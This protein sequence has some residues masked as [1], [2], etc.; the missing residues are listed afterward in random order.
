[1]SRRTLVALVGLA[2]VVAVALYVWRTGAAPQ[3][4]AD[5]AA[6]LDR[7]PLVDPK[8]AP[9]RARGLDLAPC[10][11]R[12]RVV[13]GGDRLGVGGAIVL[14]QPSGSVVGRGQRHVVR[15]DDS[16]AW[17]AADLAPGVY[18]LSA[19]AAGMEPRLRQRIVL[20]PGRD[21]SDLDLE[22][23]PG[24]MA[25]QGQIRDA[26]GG[27]VAGADVVAVTIDNAT[28][29][30]PRVYAT[31][32]D[33]QGR[34][35]LSLIAGKYGIEASRSDYAATA[36]VVHVGD[37]PREESFALVPGGVIE[38]VVR[39]RDDGRPVPR[40]RVGGGLSSAPVFMGASRVSAHADDEG[41][42]RLEGLRAGMVELRAQ[43]ESQ[44]SLTPTFVPMGVG[45]EVSGVEV[46]VSPT[47]RIS[48]Y[49]VESGNETRGI[50][51]VHVSVQSFSRDVFASARVSD[52]SDAEGYFEVRGVRPG[53]YL[54]VPMAEGWLP[55]LHFTNVGD[56]DVTDLLLTLQAGA[57]I[58][59]RVDPPSVVRIRALAQ[60]PEEEDAGIGV[61]FGVMRAMWSTFGTVRSDPD[62]RF[63]LGPVTPGRYRLEAGAV[64]RRAGHVDVEVG[65][66]GLAEV[67]LPLLDDPRVV[68]RVVDE[69][70]DP[71]AEVGVVLARVR[72]EGDPLRMTMST[73]E[74]HED[75][76]DAEGRFELR[77]VT[78]GQYQATVR[79]DLGLRIPVS[80][81]GP[82]ASRYP[83]VMVVV[84]ERR[85]PEPLELRTIVVDEGLR[86]RV[87]SPD[88][89]PL[90]GAWVVAR[91]QLDRRELGWLYDGVQGMAS[92]DS[93]GGPGEAGA[94]SETK[95]ETGDD[96]AAAEDE[97]EGN[98]FEIPGVDGQI[99]AALTSPP[100][101]TDEEGRFEIPGL[102]RRRYTVVAEAARGSL[103]TEVA[104]VNATAPVSLTL[105]P[106]ASIE[107]AL[108]DAPGAGLL[109]LE[110][111]GPDQRTRSMRLEDGPARIERLLP[112]DY[113]LDAVTELGAGRAS[114]SVEP[115]ESA[116]VPLKI[117]AYATI[118]G[119]LVGLADGKPLPQVLHFVE[120]KS[121]VDMQSAMDMIA[122][123]LGEGSSSTDS[124]G[125][126]T[127]G[128]LRPG[129]VV[130]RFT[131]PGRFGGAGAARAW[132]EPGQ[133]LDVGDVLYFRE[134]S[135][136]G[137]LG[138]ELEVRIG[139]DADANP[140]TADAPPWRL[141]VTAAE[142]GLPAARAGIEPGDEVVSV[143]GRAL[144]NGAQGQLSA[145]AA[146]SQLRHVALGEAIEFETAR[147]GVRRSHS[148]EAVAEP[149]E[150]TGASP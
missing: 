133:Q 150:E 89:T 18:T 114:F 81:E 76:T 63:T 80:A 2:V 75:R 7:T 36:R 64:G 94:E 128:R 122:G 56:E 34:Y 78:P 112:G 37:A 126:F 77:G 132:V 131:A 26:A 142:L 5:A 12:G 136:Q 57:M 105:Q 143:G 74:P 50:P 110:L 140:A 29:P 119:R 72:R 149:S 16:G 21:H 141:W 20:E 102:P 97:E 68:G 137:T 17:Q 43:G 103:R 147:G 145:N 93:A 53:R 73:A 120:S 144:G 107:L 42:F 24:G 139:K 101:L 32:A 86:G 55:S 70:G 130:I 91:P 4:T 134:P 87:L 115:G 65:L 54:T 61:I 98:S 10:S 38:G 40:A 111:D 84:E 118:E 60:M 47:F 6:E 19:T 48:G 146:R 58:E 9:R 129:W 83:K 90:A 100:V 148:L 1:M 106:L 116:S 15:A 62:G 11:A 51:G 33:K 85:D 39:N 59:G 35:S 95:V 99:V 41:R 52:P 69:D 45:E 49:V 44:G 3:P 46:L 88:G 13:R 79:D 113:E 124:E 71:V 138:L 117:E 108:E 14:L 104:D 109:E 92:L 67:A 82:V 127:L 125:R 66:D 31:Q 96:A 30:D 23:T 28:S 27:V 121:G 123:A 8:L 135:D 22:L 25:V